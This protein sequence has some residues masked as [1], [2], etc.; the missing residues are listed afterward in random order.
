MTYAEAEQ[1][2]EK[3]VHTIHKCIRIEIKEGTSSYMVRILTTHQQKINNLLAKAA[4]LDKRRYS[5]E[6][7][8]TSSP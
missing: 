5:V 8:R 7:S 3:E 2:L 1:V 4:Y 6:A